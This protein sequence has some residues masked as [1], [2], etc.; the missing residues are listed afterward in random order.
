[1]NWKNFLNADPTEWLLHSEPWVQYNTLKDLCGKKEDAPDVIKAKKALMI[2][3]H[4]QQVITTV[5][6]WPP[7]P[8]KR[9]NDAN[10]PLH[11]LAVLADF[12]VTIDDGMHSVCETILS[13]QIEGAFQIPMTIPTH[14]GGSGTPEP[15][16]MACDTPLILYSLLKMGATAH[17]GIIHTTSL[18]NDNGVLCTGALPT[19][20]GPGRKGDP[21]PYAT[22]LVTRAL[23]QIPGIKLTPLTD[24]L[25]WH[26][27]HQKERKIYL[28]GIGTTFKK[29]KYPFIWYDI[30]HVADVL[31]QINYLK[32]DERLKEIIDIIISKQDA[33]GR[34]TPESVW[35]AFK[36]WEFGQKKTP[37]PWL[38]F[39]VARILKRI[40]S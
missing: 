28:F 9:H 23:V 15:L 14:F 6:D 13:H 5:S 22:L 39:L 8:L 3:P 17:K 38:T 1:M 18:I 40:Y 30:L 19:F 21:C 16:W 36:Q 34:F 7:Y 37:S 25:L 26:W 33:A 4:I 10:H 27:E 35:M 29:L 20:R 11:H 32:N 24:M 12:G 31:S 2:H